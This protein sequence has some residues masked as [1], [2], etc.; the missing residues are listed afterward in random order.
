LKIRHA[1]NYFKNK[2]VAHRNVIV[3]D[4][5]WFTFLQNVHVYYVLNINLIFDILLLN[6]KMDSD[7]FQIQIDCS[8]DLLVFRLECTACTWKSRDVF[9]RDNPP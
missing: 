5:D 3:S 1:T 7:V 2:R 4:I 9:D 6:V 8:F